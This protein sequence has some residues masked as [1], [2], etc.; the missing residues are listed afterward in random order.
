MTSLTHLCAYSKTSGS[1][2]HVLKHKYHRLTEP[3]FRYEVFFRKEVDC[4]GAYIKLLSHS[5]HLRLVMCDIITA[6]NTVVH[7]NGFELEFIK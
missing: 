1:V 4:G 7:L 6:Y 3:S 5:D 2:Q